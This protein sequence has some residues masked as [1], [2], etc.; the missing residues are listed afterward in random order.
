MKVHRYRFPWAVL[1]IAVIGGVLAGCP[2][3]TRNG[4]LPQQ[5]TKVYDSIVKRGSIRC[6][7][8]SNPPACMK[9]PN[10]GKVSGIFVEVTEKIAQKLSLKIEW[11][12]EVGFGSMI[13]GLKA[14]RYDMV[15]CAIWPN[16]QRALQADFT[17]PLYYS[18][19]C[20]YVRKGDRR[21]VKNLKTI[22]SPNVTIAT[23]DGEMA[24]VIAKEDFPKA[25]TIQVPQLSEIT[26]MLLNLKTGKADVTFVEPYF[27]HQFL[28]NNPGSIEN[29][30]PD[31]PLRVFPN[32]VLIPKGE[33]ELKQLLNTALAESVNAGTV[34]TL[35]RKYEPAPNTF[36]RV[37]PPYRTSSQ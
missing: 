35:L 6:G 7:H 10:T 9:D 22:D 34:D 15:P 25:K 14:G 30:T 36:Y 4:A 32:T 13:E 23:M 19:V 21:F 37:T 11:T 3:P 20:A 29:I 18:G 5:T 17:S 33:Y 12:E 27:A 31:R 8:V 26:T 2:G 28:K 1:L 24:Q 16:T